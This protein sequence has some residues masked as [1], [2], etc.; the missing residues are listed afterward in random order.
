MRPYEWY[1]K[2]K[3][4]MEEILPT[5]DPDLE[6]DVD[7]TSITTNDEGEEYETF[8]LVFSHTSNPNLQWTMEIQMDDEFIAHELEQVVKKIYFE[9]VE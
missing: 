4:R 1:S 9:R 5:L 7:E 3:A 6:V 8:V 2:A